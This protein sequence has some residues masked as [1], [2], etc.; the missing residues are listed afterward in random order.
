MLHLSLTIKKRRPHL[1]RMW[2]YSNI[3]DY[4]P[5]EDL[6]IFKIFCQLY[7]ISSS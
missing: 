5:I 6:N 3:N 1:K 4:D 7:L 2:S